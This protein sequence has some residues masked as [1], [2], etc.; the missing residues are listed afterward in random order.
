M[1][2]NSKLDMIVRNE[3]RDLYENNYGKRIPVDQLISEIEMALRYIG[4]LEITDN[5]TS[6]FSDVSSGDSTASESDI[7]IL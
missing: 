3:T 7:I 5:Q 1:N 2:E 4:S 6:N